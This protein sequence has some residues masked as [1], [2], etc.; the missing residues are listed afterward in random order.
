MHY[1]LCSTHACTV[2]EHWIAK[3]GLTEILVTDN[4]TIFRN[5][6]ITTL[7]HLYK[8]K[9]EP[10]KSNAHWTNGLVEGMNRLLQE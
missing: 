2:C 1:A 4:G 7:C 9:H 10:R 6:E 5:N 8:I 3:F